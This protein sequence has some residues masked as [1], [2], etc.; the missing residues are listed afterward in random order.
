MAY[1]YD[2]NSKPKMTKEESDRLMKEIFEIKLRFARK[3]EYLDKNLNGGN[4]VDFFLK[5][6][7]FH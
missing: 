4:K 2:S 6:L 5:Y 1:E 3:W 7:F